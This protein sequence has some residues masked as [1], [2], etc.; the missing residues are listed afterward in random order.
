M[1]KNSRLLE[2]DDDL[3]DKVGEDTSQECHQFD[4]CHHSENIN[5]MANLGYLEQNHELH[6]RVYIESHMIPLI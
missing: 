4:F 6:N 3:C 5:S 1:D 2:N